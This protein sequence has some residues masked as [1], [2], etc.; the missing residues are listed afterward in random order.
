MYVCMYV[1]YRVSFQ[2][3]EQCTDYTATHA[4]RHATWLKVLYVFI[5]EAVY[6]PELKHAI[7]TA[8]VC[9]TLR[10]QLA[11]SIELEFFRVSP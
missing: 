8:S 7:R 11:Y 3:S 2:C 4:I 1:C 6:E 10:Y 9:G 5:S